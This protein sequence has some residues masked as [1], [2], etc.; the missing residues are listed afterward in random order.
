MQDDRKYTKEMFFMLIDHP[1]IQW[2]V[3]EEH[4]KVHK[5]ERRWIKYNVGLWTVYALGDKVHLGIIIDSKYRGQGY[6]R[7][8]FET[9]LEMTD[10]TG[11]DTWLKCFVGNF[12]TKMY[13]SLGYVKTMGHKTIRGRKFITMVRRHKNN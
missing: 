3:I 8:A 7:K 2:Y 13:K 9:Y 1:T 12:A 4:E 5:N 10:A 11:Y 6:S